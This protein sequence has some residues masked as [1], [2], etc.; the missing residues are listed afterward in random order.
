MYENIFS[1]I[2]WLSKEEIALSKFNSLLLLLDS[3]GLED[4]KDFST[5]SPFVVR[6]VAMELSEVLKRNL[7]KKIEKS[8]AFAVLTDEATDIS[9]MQQLLTF[10][11]YPDS[12]KNARYLFCKYLTCCL[13]LKT[14]LLML[15]QYI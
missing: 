9:N 8:K 4:I 13:S 1:V 6:H 15:N 5:R 2:Y 12:K 14:L 11:K 7:A 3:L 10:I